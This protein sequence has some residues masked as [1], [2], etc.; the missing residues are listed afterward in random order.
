M[1]ISRAH[2][3]RLVNRIAAEEQR[4][5][6]LRDARGLPAIPLDARESNDLEML[7]VGALSPLEGYMGREDYESVC[8]RG[9]LAGGIP[10]TLPICL[11]A[12]AE[13]AEGLE[14]GSRIALAG[15]GGEI[16]GLMDLVEKF[17]PDKELEAEKVLRT[18]DSKH[19]GVVYLQ[20][21]GELYLGGPITLLRRPSHQR[22]ERFRLDPKETRVL[23]KA[24]GWNSIAAFQ[25]RNPIHRAHEYLQKCALEVVDALLI[26][27]IMGQTKADDIPAEVRLACYQVLLERYYPKDR[28]ALSIL[29]AA[30]RYAG[31]REAVFHAIMRK[32]YGCTHFIVGR[33]HAGVGGYYGTYDAHTIFKEFDRLEI[34]ITP[35]FFD[36]AFYCK[37]CENMGSKKTCPHDAA[38]HVFLSGTKIR[39]MLRRGETL[40][41]EFTRPEVAE[42]LQRWFADSDGG[43]QGERA[44]PATAAA[45]GAW[46]HP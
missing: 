35:L 2:G 26:H 40:P 24:K 19:P 30:M 16:L 3:G 20:G 28:V 22:F 36:H 11:S 38:S 13:Q 23:F 12:T 45:D 8:R 46:P 41:R 14:V 25:T 43:G 29:P 27:P 17:R 15:S 1:A 32:N 4:D 44:A 18:T 37:E 7:A 33:D 5:Q 34:G 42:I 31:P 21:C 39:D 10:W 9:R 6:L